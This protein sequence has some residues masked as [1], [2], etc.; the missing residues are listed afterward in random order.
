[1]PLASFHTASNRTQLVFAC[2]SDQNFKIFEGLG[3]RLGGR[4]V[5]FPEDALY[6]I[7][8]GALACLDVDR[9]LMTYNEAVHVL[10][11]YIDPYC[12]EAY[13]S[14]K[15]MGLHVRRAR[16]HEFEIPTRSNFTNP[17]C[18]TFEL[19]R[20]VPASIMG[21]SK[22][23]KRRRQL[24]EPDYAVSVHSPNENMRRCAPLNPYPIDP[25]NPRSGPGQVLHAILHI[26]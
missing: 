26:G 10:L 5:I 21:S 17:N 1:M 16:G 4:R 9:V 15:K 6:L 11:P 12:Y 18:V 19:W 13:R 8:Q 22:A 14:G 3:I 25:K 2:V 23:A 7:E 24:P 20:R